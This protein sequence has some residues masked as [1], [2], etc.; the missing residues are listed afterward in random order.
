MTPNYWCTWATQA[1]T[2]K[3][4]AASGELAFDGDQGA[5]AL[6]GRNNLDEK[7][8]F[9]ENGWIHDFPEIRKNM[10]FLFDDGWDVPR[11]RTVQMCEFGSLELNQ[12]RF[13]SFPGSPAERL[14]AL[15]EKV[16]SCGWGGTGI[17]IAAQYPVQNPEQ[18]GSW[19]GAEA[20]WRE[21]L[22]WS[23]DAGI[24]LWKVDWGQFC[25]DVSFRE[26]LTELAAEIAPELVV[27]HA[28]PSGA[29]CG[30]GTDG[31]RFR[32][33]P[34][35]GKTRELLHF[36]KLLRT[37]DTII[38][39]TFATTL[40]R[41][42]ALLAYGTEI[43]SPTMLCVEDCAYIAAGLGCSMGIMRS[44]RW[45]EGPADALMQRR[46]RVAEVVRAVR[47]QQLAP[48]WDMR[49][50][51]YE[52]SREILSESWVYT[53]GETWYSPVFGKTVT[54]SAPAVMA[55]NMPLPEVETTGRTPYVQASLYPN[56][57][58]AVNL[59]P[60]LT[61]N[62]GFEAPD[63]AV[64]LKI[65][66]RNRKIGV[67]GN[68][69]ELRLPVGEGSFRIVGRDL[70]KDEERDLSSLCRTEHGFAVVPGTVAE[71]LCGREI[72]A[73]GILLE[74]RA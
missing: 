18:Y 4:R 33:L 51:S 57:V 25:S 64:T 54:Q 40:D 35:C 70:A 32:D 23:R 12:E 24:S 8:V 63:A 44:A 16:R 42:D 67:F 19:R 11:N 1:M 21:R 48:A 65:D 9:G 41:T 39:H 47:F 66:C 55:R 68:F 56:G 2:A 60:R 34:L 74:V 58:A 3:Q 7:A 37:Y 61:P 43:H 13:P 53:A 38:P 22:K 15:A 27:E 36:S 30:N 73:P 71:I 6:T 5:N 46:K 31:L 72:S 49:T 50:G 14:K 69:G 59:V 28:M 45:E 17:W 62:I 52:A 29:L 26:F 20:F 10:F